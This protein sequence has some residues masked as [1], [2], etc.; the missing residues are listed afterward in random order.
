MDP[1]LQPHY[2]GKD[3]MTG[4]TYAFLMQH[5]SGKSL[6][7]DVGIRKDWENYAPVLVENFKKKGWELGAEKNTAEIL[8]ENDVDVQGGAIDT[9]I[10]SHRKTINLSQNHCDEQGK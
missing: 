7:F 10:W 9:V 5:P 3:F 4:P 8:Q 6:L 1:F 2:K